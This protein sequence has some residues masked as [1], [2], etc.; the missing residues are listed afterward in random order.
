MN[1]TRQYAD[2]RACSNIKHALFRTET[3]PNFDDL[4]KMGNYTTPE[5]IGE[6]GERQQL[7]TEAKRGLFYRV[8]LLNGGKYRTRG[9][10]PPDRRKRGKDGRSGKGG[11]V[12]EKGNRKQCGRSEQKRPKAARVVEKCSIYRIFPGCVVK[13]ET[14]N[15]CVI[16]RG[17]RRVV[18]PFY[19]T[20]LSF[21]FLFF[22][23]CVE[24]DSNNVYK[25]LYK[26]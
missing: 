25:K 11:K 16:L 24:K 1:N 18:F 19:V 22:P 26:I 12:E 20:K 23:F 6:I 7:T 14:R 8:E 9:E 5:E 15:G 3:P 4:P 13:M 21:S 10:V 2:F 17:L